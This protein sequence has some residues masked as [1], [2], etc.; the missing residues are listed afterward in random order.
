M[1]TFDNM[2]ATY[3]PLCAARNLSPLTGVWI[4]LS[5][6]WTGSSRSYERKWESQIVYLRV[7]MTNDDVMQ[8]DIWRHVADIFAGWKLTIAYMKFIFAE[9]LLAKAPHPPSFFKKG[10]I[11][12]AVRIF[13][14]INKILLKKQ[15]S[16]SESKFD[17]G[18]R[19][20]A[21]RGWCSPYQS[22]VVA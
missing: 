16:V 20:S 10:S 11:A 1:T 15:L 8:E 22:G 19:Q 14:R 5:T 6:C 12:S 2:L 21:N 7:M 13:A 9:P 3:G 17:N 4:H 18:F